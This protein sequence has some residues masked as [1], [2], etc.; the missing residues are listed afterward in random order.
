VDVAIPTLRSTP[1]PAAPTRPRASADQAPQTEA[2]GYA[3]TT[4]RCY[5]RGPGRR[6]QRSM[7]ASPDLPFV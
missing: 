3:G 5:N 6:R 7:D 1:V 2:P 4:R